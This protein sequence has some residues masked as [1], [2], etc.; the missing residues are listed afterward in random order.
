[1]GLILNPRLAVLL[2][3]GLP[4]FGGASI[5]PAGPQAFLLGAWAG[6]LMA[7][8]PLMLLLLVCG[9]RDAGQTLRPLLRWPVI[10]AGLAALAWMAGGTLGAMVAGGGLWWWLRRGRF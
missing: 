8:P 2:L 5:N 1:M 7:A 3:I 9:V 4:L 10:C 6:W